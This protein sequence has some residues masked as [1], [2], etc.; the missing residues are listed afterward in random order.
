MLTTTK[1]ATA[2]KPTAREST[3]ITTATEE[4]EA[5]NSRNIGN[6][7]VDGINRDCRNANRDSGNSEEDAIKHMRPQQNLHDKLIKNKMFPKYKEIQNGAGATSYMTNGLRK[8]EEI[9]AQF[10]IY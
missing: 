1:L 10:L 2:G 7:R 3:A 8:Y 5:N 9:F 6:S 4:S